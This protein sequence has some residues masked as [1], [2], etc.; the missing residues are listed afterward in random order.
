MKERVVSDGDEI[1]KTV[2]VVLGGDACHL[3][4]KVLSFL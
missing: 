2:L 1:E 3:V 4:A